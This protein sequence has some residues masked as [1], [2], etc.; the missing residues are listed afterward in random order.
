[1]ADSSVHR[2]LCP[3]IRVLA[4]AGADA[5]A[6]RRGMP[7][8]AALLRPLEAHTQ[9]VEVRTLQL[10]SRS[11][12]PFAVRFESAAAADTRE[13]FGTFLDELAAHARTQMDTYASDGNDWPLGEQHESPPLLAYSDTASFLYRFRPLTHFDS[14]GHTAA[15]V[16]A[17]ASDAP[18]PMNE[19]ARLYEAA[20]EIDA[21][22]YYLVVHDDPA[23]AAPDA[24]AALPLLAE[25]RRTYGLQCGL[26][27]LGAPG[28][29]AE[30]AADYAAL[31]SRAAHSAPAVSA[32]DAERIRAFVRDLVAK[33][34][35]PYL[36]RSVQ[37]LN[38][39][40]AAARRG[41]T[42]RLLGASR[43]LFG[44]PPDERD[45]PPLSALM[46]RLADM[47]F[48][49]R[50]YRLAANMYELLRRTHVTERAPLPAAYAAEMLCISRLLHAHTSRTPAAM[51]EP[52]LAAA[53]DEYIAAGA[54]W[55]AIRAAMLC[56]DI[57]RLMRNCE[58]EA[59]ALVRAAG[60][61]EE[62]LSGILYEA[63]AHAY[64]RMPRAH[65]R[66]S[67]AMLAMAAERYRACGAAP[68]ATRCLRRC[69]AY[70]EARGWRKAYGHVCMQLALQAHSDGHLADAITYLGA[71][72][73]C[74]DPQRDGEY[75]A[76]FVQLFRFGGDKP[77]ELARPVWSTDVRIEVPERRAPQPLAA[78]G[79]EVHLHL[80]A[81][82]PLSVPLTLTELSVHCD[83]AA[84]QRPAD[85]IALAPHET[86]HV[87]VTLCPREAGDL[88]I[89]HLEY[90]LEDTARITQP[91]A[92]RGARLNA[93]REHR[94]HPTYAPD[95]LPTVDVRA[96]LPLLAVEMEAPAT[97]FV[98]ETLPLRIVI[99]NTGSRAA[100]DVRLSS[101]H[102]VFAH[103]DAPVDES[104]P[105]IASIASGTE[106]LIDA[107]AYAGE[108]GAASLVVHAAYDEFS[109][110][111]VHAVSVAPLLDVL[112][113]VSFVDGKTYLLE[114]GVQC[115]GARADIVGASLISPT[116]R[117]ADPH[118]WHAA[119]VQ[120]ERVATQ[121]HLAHEPLCMP[122]KHTLAQ[123]HALQYGETPVAHGPTDMHAEFLG[124]AVPHDLPLL[125]AARRPSRMA[126]LANAFAGLSQ[127]A[128][129]AFPF[130]GANDLDVI[131]HWTAGAATG[132]TLASAAIGYPE[133]LDD[134]ASLVAPARTRAMYEDTVRAQAHMLAVL[135]ASPLASPPAPLVVRTKAGLPSE[136]TARVEFTILNASPLT[137]RYM[138]ALAPAGTHVPLARDHL[139][140]PWLGR[141]KLRGSVAPHGRA[142]VD[143]LALA[144]T[145]GTFQ[146]GDWACDAHTD[147]YAW[148][149]AGSA[150]TLVVPT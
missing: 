86:A 143:A 45:S 77:V 34:L 147:A 133:V 102:A 14:L 64:L 89:T 91:L 149:T 71:L 140:V 78:V 125:A 57:Q 146:L 113:H 135:R 5:A 42:G 17:V 24:A 39:Q 119:L 32:A 144:P 18:E 53:C 132:G 7:D 112:L 47:A 13:P 20:S 142:V 107:R 58:F 74:T 44:A 139:A 22:R 103:P 124:N 15:V 84:E 90:L 83:R 26:L 59:R 138:L 95:V 56:A 134:P 106:A 111:A 129:R 65:V 94:I 105:T 40:V 79:E 46:T 60:V 75:L 136:H 61:A 118:A 115:V 27:T 80:V 21:L 121:V 97:A 93:T 110:E 3:R 25:V 99:R 127:R 131:V 30:F 130:F 66:K 101:P 19:F 31:D 109:T 54:R 137:V 104:T 88:H 92:R 12:S 117:A 68:L 62:V 55:H 72:L 10:E 145:P 63:A 98:G 81:T 50:D 73:G 108:A 122:L 29:C 100:E 51:L 11:C 8:L 70:Y 67:A 28:E 41:L 87:T 2:A 6:R 128:L 48:Y 148:C 49:V 82:N 37:Q 52:L 1:M 35:V 16:L 141:T 85:M 36:E 23:S 4:G 114:L 69:T 76:E 120:G 150:D 38:E 96:A 33:S 9:H 123:L 116:W 43:R 126:A